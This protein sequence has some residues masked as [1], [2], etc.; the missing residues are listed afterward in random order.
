MGEY[1]LNVVLQKKGPELFKELIRLYPLAEIEDYYKGGQWNSE[2]IKMDIQVFF[3]H[4]EEAGAPEPPPIEEVKTGTLPAGISMPTPV[5]TNGFTQFPAAAGLQ[6]QQGMMTGAELQLIVNFANKHKLDLVRTKTML[7]S[8][9]APQRF[10]VIGGFAPKEAKEG[11]ENDIHKQLAAFI[12]EKKTVTPLGLT[13]TAS[14]V[15]PKVATPVTAQTAKA[16]PVANG[17]NTPAATAATA[18]AAVPGVVA[19]NM[20]APKQ[21][22]PQMMDPNKRPRLMTPQPVAA[23]GV[24]PVVPGPVAAGAIPGPAIRPVPPRPGMPAVKLG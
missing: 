15:T 16:L 19:P 20:V 23:G 7:S 3:A 2:L 24:R 18:P 22:P 21:P 5:P 11:E 12:A 4:R 1:Y 13:V 8:L 17:A 10:A 6:A 9:P 14:T